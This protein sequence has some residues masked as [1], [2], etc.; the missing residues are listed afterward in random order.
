MVNGCSESQVRVAVAVEIPYRQVTERNRG[1]LERLKRPI[2]VPQHD[3]AGCHQ[4]QVPITVKVRDCKGPCSCG[5]VRGGV[6]LGCCLER[7]IAIAQEDTNAGVGYGVVQIIA[8][9]DVEMA[10]AVK[11]AHGHG[12]RKRPD[13]GIAL[14]GPESTIAVAQ[15]ELELIVTPGSRK[16]GDAILVKVSNR[17][18]ADE[19]CEGD[20]GRLERAVAIA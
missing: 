14:P 13:R 10:I 16:V 12:A 17:N 5:V 6:V 20:L 19:I 18:R 8:D 11:I 2:A 15:Q 9:S 7:A 4:V 3:A 1:T